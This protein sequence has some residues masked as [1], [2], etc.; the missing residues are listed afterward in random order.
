MSQSVVEHTRELG[1]R[2]ALGSGVFR[3]IR[4]A[5]LPGLFLALAGVAAG[6]AIA[7]V[8]VRVFEHLLWG[9]TATDPLTFTSV[10]LGLVLVAGF[11]SLIPALRI[12]RLKPADTLRED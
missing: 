3:A 11:A 9:V 2:L 7:A 4:D 1:I 6:C 12:T 5:A 10:A 8:S